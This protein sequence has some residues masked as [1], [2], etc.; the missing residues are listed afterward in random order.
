[1]ADAPSVPSVASSRGFPVRKVVALLIV[2]LGLAVDLWSKDWM[3]T[4]LGMDA[5]RPDVSDIVELVPGAFRLQGHWNPGITFGMLPHRTGPILTFT[6]LACLGIFIAIL[7]NRSRSG[8]LHVAL[9][10]ILGGA[11]GNLYDRWQ[12]HKVRDFLVVYWKD[13]SIWQWPAFNAADS[14][15]VVGVILVLWREFFGRGDVPST[16]TAAPVAPPPPAPGNAP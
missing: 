16:A 15:I 4:R 5:D 11:L 1:M 3:Q 6:V 2:V 7:V 14:F 9:A 8:L 10:L 13:P 12:W